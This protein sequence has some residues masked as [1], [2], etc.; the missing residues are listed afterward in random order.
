[1]V[2]SREEGN[3]ASTYDELYGG[4]EEHGAAQHQPLRLQ[5]AFEVEVPFD[6]QCY[7]LAP[8]I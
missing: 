5:H 7:A 1:M 3:R 4:D 6:H 8:H 2:V